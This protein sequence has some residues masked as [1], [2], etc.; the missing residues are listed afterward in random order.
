MNKDPYFEALQKKGLVLDCTSPEDVK[1]RYEE[2]HGKALYLGWIPMLC[3]LVQDQKN[4]I[5]KK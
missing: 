5:D 2:A 3:V 1:K 4:K